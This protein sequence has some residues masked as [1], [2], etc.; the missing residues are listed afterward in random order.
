MGLLDLL[1]TPDGV[2]GMGLLAAGAAKPGG[3][4]FGEGLMGAVSQSNAFKQA[5]Q[6]REMKAMLMQAQVAD[7]QA[8]AQQREAQA[9]ALQQKAA[10]QQRIQALLGNAFAPV[11]PIQANAAS[12][13]A[14]HRPEALGVVGQAPAV[15]YQQLMADGVPADLVKALAESRNYGREK[16]ARALDVAQNGL[17]GTQQLDDYG[18]KV[19]AW[20]PK[21]VEMKLANLGGSD[22]AYNPFALQEGQSFT[23]TQSPDSAAS[24][25]VAW[26]RL[27]QD[28]A[29]AAQSAAAGQLIDTPQGYV[30]VGKDN[31]ATA[32]MA[33][34]G[35]QPLMGN[36][37]KLHE[38]A[39]KQVLGARNVQQAVADY[40]SKLTDWGN[41]KMLSPDARAEMGNAYNNMMLQAKEAYNLGVLNGP[42]YTILQSVV[43][44]PTKWTSIAVSNEALGKQAAEL[45]RIAANIEKNSMQAHGKP[46][47]P[48]SPESAGP[49]IPSGFRVL[50]KE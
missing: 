42:D 28:K 19:G 2:F 14:G 48:F 6:D 39:Q 17:P 32:I 35:V 11:S 18:N 5:Q 25:Q 44:D 31:R 43:K 50:G 29:Q 47:T 15:N 4:S 49:A 24:N 27:A 26:A 20:M 10:E 38:A 8:Q 34:T 37:S 30:R 13:I 12:G 22:R 1:N 23:R 9:K 36:G 21:A 41:T 16:V 45:A 40:K 7:M 33:P 46:Y 3:T